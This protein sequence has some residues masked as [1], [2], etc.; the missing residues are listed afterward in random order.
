MRRKTSDLPAY[1]QAMG[2]LVRR[3]HSRRE[4][5]QKLRQRGKEAE[6]IDTALESLSRQD[7]QNDSRFAMALARS[8]QAAGY[9]P[10]RIRAELAQHSLGAELIAETMASLSDDWLDTAQGLVARR[11]LRKIQSDPAQSRKAADFL[12]RRGFDQKTAFTAVKI[13]EWPVAPDLI[14]ESP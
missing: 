1:Q 13:R 5:K 6:E 10:V 3:E 9:G 14:D 8:R 4:L 12:L 2:L 11:Y 7:F